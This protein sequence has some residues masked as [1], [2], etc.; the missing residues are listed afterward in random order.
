MTTFLQLATVNLMLI[1]YFVSGIDK[2]SHFTK[3]VDGFRSKLPV[4]NLY[5]A[6]LAILAAIVIEIVGPILI[7]YGHFADKRYAIYGLLSLIV[8]TVLA[9][10]IYHFPPVGGQYYPFMSNLTALGGLCTALTLYAT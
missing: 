7:N 9:T 1:M 2:I 6:R 10:L 4:I 5:F 3:T 8:F